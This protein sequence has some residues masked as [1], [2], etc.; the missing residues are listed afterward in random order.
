MAEEWITK[1]MDVFGSK[2]TDPVQYVKMN[3][4]EPYT[5]RYLKPEQLSSQLQDFVSP[6]QLL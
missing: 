3:S 1:A 2:D 5:E 6:P 4:D